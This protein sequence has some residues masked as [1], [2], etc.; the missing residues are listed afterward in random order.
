MK[1]VL[2][3]M[4]GDYAPV[5][6][7]A[8]AI[9]FAQETGHTVFLVGQ[10]EE[11]KTELSKYDTQGLSLPIVDA[12]DVIAMD[13]KPAM[14]VRRKKK[15]SMVVGM[16]LVKSGQ[17]DAF[18]SVGHTGAVLT[19]G[20]LVFRRMHGVH[21]AV[22]VSPFPNKKGLHILGDIG[23]NADCKPEWLVQ[24]AHM[25][26][27]YATARLGIQAPRVAILSNGEEEGKGNQLVKDVQGQL[28]SENDLN[29]IGVVE[30]KEML[31]GDADVV[32]T[33]GFTGNVVIKLSEAIAKYLLDVLKAE[34]MA[35]PTAKIGGLLAKPA[36]RAAAAR[37][38]DR[39]YGVGLL[40][41]L[42]GVVTVGH[43]R[44]KRDGVDAALHATALLV[45][46]NVLE[47]VHTKIEASLQ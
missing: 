39:E 36:F 16:N 14:A 18:C 47:K 34:I 41:G 11:I 37:L 40:L 44:S 15:N 12:P 27:I 4:G 10:S 20:H 42:N 43:G 1:L 13:E 23:A 6:T 24:W 30:P 46:A 22:L 28:A 25:M 32:V 31:A 19:A 21:R 9:K 7:V 5:E 26:A 3:A 33:D 17:A 35:R 29:Y 8:G 45:E 2:D 38:D